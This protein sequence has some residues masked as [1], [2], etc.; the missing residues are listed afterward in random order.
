MLVKLN[1]LTVKFALLLISDPSACDF[2]RNDMC[3]Y[4]TTYSDSNFRWRTTN[5]NYGKQ[6]WL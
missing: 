4:R 1:D 3:G 2:Y 5:N 6:I